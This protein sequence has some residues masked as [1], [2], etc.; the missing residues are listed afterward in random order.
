LSSTLF[1]LAPLTFSRK[2]LAQPAA[3]NYATRAG[4]VGA[5]AFSRTLNL[6]T[7]DCSDPKV[8]RA[9]GDVPDSLPATEQASIEA[10]A[11]SKL[12]AEGT[13]PAYMSQTLIK[14][15]KLV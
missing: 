15:E 7:G 8:I 4:N 3:S 14:L 2:I 1:D 13:I 5:V 6:K 10:L 11:R 12:S 9:S